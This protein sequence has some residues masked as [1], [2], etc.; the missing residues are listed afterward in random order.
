MLAPLTAVV[1]G[2]FKNKAIRVIIFL[3]VGVTCAQAGALQFFFWR[4]YFQGHNSYKYTQGHQEALNY[5]KELDGN[6]KLQTHHGNHVN[7]NSPYLYFFTGKDS[8]LGG[9]QILESHNQ[10]IEDRL[11]NVE[12][13]FD[14]S[15]SATMAAQLANELEISHVLLGRIGYE[16]IFINKFLNTATMSAVNHWQSVFENVE[17]VIVKPVRPLEK[18]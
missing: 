18:N 14:V 7:S 16:G 11:Q 4:N 10:R 8:Y 3:M 13:I 6:I 12:Y 1:L 17:F 5:L 9:I 2:S 15:G